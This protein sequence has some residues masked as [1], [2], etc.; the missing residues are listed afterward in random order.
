[1]RRISVD[2]RTTGLK[3][4]TPL[5]DAVVPMNTFKYFIPERLWG[6]LLCY[7]FAANLFPT[8]RI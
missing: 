1:V 6:H 4:I 2:L 8:L 3:V 5:A 7:Q